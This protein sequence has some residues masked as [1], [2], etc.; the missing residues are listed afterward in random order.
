MQ[1]EKILTSFQD[2]DDIWHYVTPPATWEALMGSEG[3]MLMRKNEKI[4]VVW[5]V[6]N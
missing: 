6:I 1:L 5:I 2:G 4:A 3:Y